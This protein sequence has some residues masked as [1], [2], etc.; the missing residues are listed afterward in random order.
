MVIEALVT[1]HY[2]RLDALTGGRD[3]DLIERLAGE[4]SDEL[5]YTGLI[6]TSG[7]ACG[8]KGA[9]L[10]RGSKDDIAADFT[11]IGYGGEI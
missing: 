7:D 5:E 10:F 1:W 3:G 11:R 4:S 6:E 9:I 2:V 8:R